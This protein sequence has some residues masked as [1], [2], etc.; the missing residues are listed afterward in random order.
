MIELYGF[1][2]SHFVEKARWA[3]DFKGVPYR[4]IALLPG[5]HLRQVRRMAPRSTVPVLRDGDTVIQGSQDVSR[6]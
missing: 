3:L 5:P 4:W 2:I 6:S 1:T